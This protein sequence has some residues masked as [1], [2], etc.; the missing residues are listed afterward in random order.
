MSERRRVRATPRSRSPR[1]PRS[2]GVNE[3]RAR[4]ASSSLMYLAS[5]SREPE[6]R[7]WAVGW[8]Y[9]WPDLRSYQRSAR[10]ANGGGEAGRGGGFGTTILRDSRVLVLSLCGR[11]G[12][13]PDGRTC[14]GAVGACVVCLVVVDCLGGVVLRASASALSTL[15]SIL[16]HSLTTHLRALLSSGAICCLDLLC[17]HYLDGAPVRCAADPHR[18]ARRQT[19]PGLGFR[20]D[21][22]RSGASIEG[23]NA[24]AETVRL[25]QDHGFLTPCAFSCRRGRMWCSPAVFVC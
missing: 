9:S 18:W 1:A 5:R 15:L 13:G 24:T 4:R 25:E 8:W 6:T 2:A 14:C 11:A 20:L 7:V 23:W 10:R 19:A 17:R 16:Q 12:P 22:G 21:L 3:R